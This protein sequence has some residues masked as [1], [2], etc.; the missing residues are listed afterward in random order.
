MN[1][2]RSILVIYT[3]GTIGM[4]QDHESGA[5]KPLDFDKLYTYLPSLENLNCKINVQSFENLIDSSNMNP[6]FWCQLAEAI[7]TNYEH[8]D[9]FVILHGS[10][11]MAYSASVLSFMLENLNKPVI[12]TGSQLPL[13]ITRSDGRD[14]FINAIEIASAYHDETPIVPEVAIYFENNLLRGNRSIKFNAENFEAFISSNYAPLAEVGVHIRYRHDLI[15]RPNFKKLRVHKKLDSNIVILK[16]FPGITQQSIHGILSIPGLKG[17][18]LE[19][20]GSGNAPT[21]P[22]FI[23]ALNEALSQNIIIYNVTQCKSGSVD[24]GMYETSIDMG[25]IGVIGGADITTE[26]AIA[27]MMYL[28]GRGY[29]NEEIKTLLQKSLRGEITI[30]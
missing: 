3:G 29:T 25:K 20:Y 4:V 18:I 5:L 14:N 26:A 6:V 24:L 9:G 12:F 21:E 13:G 10:D 22:W 17:V 7:E 1:Q 28:F 15:M 30:N 27:K 11:T 8:Y 23:N 2:K 16:L 19:T